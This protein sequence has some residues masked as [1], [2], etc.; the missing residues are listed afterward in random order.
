MKLIRDW[1]LSTLDEMGSYDIS[2]P[3]L[4]NSIIPDSIRTRMYKWYGI[5]FTIGF[6]LAF[7]WL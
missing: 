6:L 2:Q 1:F 5:I 4:R 3:I 7:Y